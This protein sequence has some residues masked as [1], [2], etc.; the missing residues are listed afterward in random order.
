MSKL[1]T[2]K[3]L[4]FFYSVVCLYKGKA[5]Q[6]ED[7]KLHVE[8]KGLTLKGGTA[9]CVQGGE[10]KRCCHIMVDFATANGKTA[11]PLYMGQNNFYF[12]NHI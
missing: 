4:T 6:V 1:G 3:P 12:L 5:L 7:H 11:K 9:L 2:G 8:L 10:K